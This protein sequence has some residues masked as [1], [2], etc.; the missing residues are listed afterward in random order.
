M[1]ACTINAKNAASDGYDEATSSNTVAVSVGKAP[2]TISFSLPAGPMVLIA[3]DVALSAT[4]DA[5][6][7]AVNSFTSKTTQVCEVSGATLKFYTAGTCTVTA[8]QAGDNTYAA[9][10][11]DASVQVVLPAGTSSTVAGS[12]AAG[13][14][15]ASIVGGDGWVFGPQNASGWEVTGFYP[16]VSEQP[17]ANLEFPAGLFGF[18]AINGPKGTAVTIQLTYPITFPS[19]AEYWKYGK[20]SDNPT[21]HWYKL[22]GAVVSGNTVTFSVTDGGTGD[23]DLLANSVILD[24]GGVAINKAPVV[25][26]AATPVPGLGAWAAASLSLLLALAAGLGLQRQRGRQR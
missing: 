3:P 26:P 7:L 14:V 10:E 4:T 13:A 2:Q 18:T 5:S 11:K 6:G 17:P 15:S 19:N 20:T 22:P 12:I 24:P 1:G 25:T 23:S 8:S 9:A 21:A 16:Q